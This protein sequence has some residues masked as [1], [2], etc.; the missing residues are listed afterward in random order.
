MIKKLTR[1]GNSVA[2]VLDKPILEELGLDED[3]E[4]EVST[5]GQIIVIAPKRHASRERRFR[6]SVE[7]INQKYAG[8]FKRLSE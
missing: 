1:T 4:V 5:N 7:K 6:K 3:S 2:V 8:L